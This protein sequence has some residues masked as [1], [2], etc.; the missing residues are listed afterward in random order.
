MLD[1][2]RMEERRER[3]FDRT[4]RLR[5]LFDLELSQRPAPPVLLSSL[6]SIIRHA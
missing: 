4:R 5:G 2:N 1:Q 6:G 3:G